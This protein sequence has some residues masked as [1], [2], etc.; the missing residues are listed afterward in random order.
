MLWMD[1]GVAW[2]RCSVLGW[3]GLHLCGMVWLAMC[4]GS[5][6]HVC[7]RGGGGPSVQTL[8]AQPQIATTPEG[9]M[10][11]AVGG[12]DGY[13][14]TGR[15]GWS[16]PWMGWGRADGMVVMD[17]KSVGWASRWGAGRTPDLKHWP[18]THVRICGGAGHCCM[19]YCQCRNKFE[20]CLPIHPHPTHIRFM[21]CL[22][23]LCSPGSV[24]QVGGSDFEEQVG[25]DAVKMSPP[26][27]VLV[28]VS[29]CVEGICRAGAR[30]P[31]RS[32][33]DEEGGGGWE[34]RWARRLSLWGRDSGCRVESMDVFSLVAA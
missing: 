17:G 29:M 2:V 10:N 16:G 21:P 22:T 28:F 1:W 13:G 14:A 30:S 33:W 12:M 26:A 7:R 27:C 5:K 20:V 8:E 18:H 24:S 6:A 15:D 31:S 23:I 34:R 11:Q 3:T 19:R 32:D 9:L 4:N 25:N